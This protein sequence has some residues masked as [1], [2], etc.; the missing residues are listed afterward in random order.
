M[1]NIKIQNNSSTTISQLVPNP[2]ATSHPCWTRTSIKPRR[3]GPP[4][5]FT[6]KMQLLLLQTSSAI[7]FRP[8]SKSIF[9]ASAPPSVG[10]WQ[11]RKNRC[12]Y[13]S[14]ESFV[15]MLTTWNLKMKCKTLNGLT[16]GKD[17]AH[18]LR[19]WSCSEQFEGLPK[20]W[21]KQ[22]KQIKNRKCH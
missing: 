5:P 14:S 17:T 19:W 9:V 4:A 6:I 20:P 8:A 18:L 1:T 7:Q 13:T 11:T 3:L 15:K 21:R 2:K 10:C 12:I 22:N 16:F